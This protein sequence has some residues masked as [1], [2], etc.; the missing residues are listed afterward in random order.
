MKTVL[1]IVAV[2]LLLS[3]ATV[4]WVRVAPVDADRWHVSP[5]EAEDPGDKG[6]RLVEGQ[7]PRFL[8]TPDQVIAALKSVAGTKERVRLIAED[9]RMITFEARTKRMQFPDYLT[10]DVQGDGAGTRL[11]ILSRSRF[12]QSDLGVNAKRLKRWLSDLRETLGETVDGEGPRWEKA[13]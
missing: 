3:L 9:D 2:I 1:A 7:A 8:A 12:G 11:D 13:S 10:F 4:V 6:V 5:R